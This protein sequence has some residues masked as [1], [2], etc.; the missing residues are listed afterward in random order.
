M[1]V[2]A[3]PAIPGLLTRTAFFWRILKQ[4][5]V[6]KN[7]TQ[8]REERNPKISFSRINKLVQEYILT[9]KEGTDWYISG[10]H[11][12]KQG[13]IKKLIAFTPI[14]FT[15]GMVRGV[16][17]VENPSQNLWGVGVVAPVEE[18]SGLVRRFQINQGLLVGFFLLLL[19]AD[20]LSVDGGGL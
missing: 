17:Q 15:K 13:Q 16:L 12:E 19:M 2:P 5:F 1:C 14:I 6:G 4:S 7:Q 11:R 3:R 8:V 20:Q 9:G 10:W 18:V